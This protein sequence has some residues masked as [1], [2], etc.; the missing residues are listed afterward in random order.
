[1]EESRSW[2]IDAHFPGGYRRTFQHA[3]EGAPQGS[4][5]LVRCGAEAD[6][7]K[8]L[9]CGVSA[10]QHSLSSAVYRATKCDVETH[11]QRQIKVRSFPVLA[12]H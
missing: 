9:I 11:R 7:Y 5:N 6:V 12:F 8:V 2:L 10:A 3:N 4:S 1:M